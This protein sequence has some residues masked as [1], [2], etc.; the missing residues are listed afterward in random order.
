MHTGS[1]ATLRTRCCG[2][3]H[4]ML[5]TRVFTLE[6]M[7]LSCLFK[8]VSCHSVTAAMGDGTVWF[9]EEEMEEDKLLLLILA[10]NNKRQRKWVHEMNL[11]RAKYGKYHL[12]QMLEDDEEPR[13]NDECNI[14][15][16]RMKNV[17]CNATTEAFEVRN[18]FIEYFTSEGSVPWQIDSHSSLERERVG[19]GVWPRGIPKVLTHACVSEAMF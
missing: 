11:A 5:A 12:M 19:I 1:E 17:G 18:K 2:R 9:L 7:P 6:E 14:T 15:L 13:S 10:L 16:L 4:A 3:M 8:K